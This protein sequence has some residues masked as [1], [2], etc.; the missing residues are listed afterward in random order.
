VIGLIMKTIYNWVFWS[1]I[2]F[3]SVGAPYNAK[4]H[5][6]M[7]SLVV[8]KPIGLGSHNKVIAVEGFD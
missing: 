6:L 7:F 2:A 4:E 8:K 3:E 5:Q 1:K